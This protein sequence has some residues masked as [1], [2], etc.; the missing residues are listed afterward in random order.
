MFRALAAEVPFT[1][2]LATDHWCPFCARL[3][4]SPTVH[5]CISQKMQ[6]YL[7]RSA[8]G[9]IKQTCKSNA[10][11][12]HLAYHPNKRP[13]FIRQSLSTGAIEELCECVRVLVVQSR[14]AR[15]SG[16][17]FDA[18]GLLVHRSMVPLLARWWIYCAGLITESCS[19]RRLRQAARYAVHI[20]ASSSRQNVL[21]FYFWCNLLRELV[22]PRCMLVQ[23][24]MENVKHH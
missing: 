11:S 18:S 17:K 8:T 20:A 2:T 13:L 4:Q 23:G 9:Y 16:S 1:R 24:I 7:V 14:C 5:R 19:G 10:T 12:I 21:Y 3:M 22:R 15:C 6:A